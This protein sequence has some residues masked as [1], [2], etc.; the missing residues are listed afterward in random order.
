MLRPLR[1]RLAP[2]LTYAVLDAATQAAAVASLTSTLLTGDI[3]LR[4]LRDHAALKA[5]FEDA[6]AAF[7]M[8]ARQ[9]AAM[10]DT[11]TTSSTSIGPATASVGCLTVAQRVGLVAAVATAC[12]TLSWPKLMDK[13]LAKDCVRMLQDLSDA[14]L[15][16][17]P[18]RLAES[19]VP[20]VVTMLLSVFSPRAE[21]T[22]PVS[23]SLVTPSGLIA[24][25]VATPTSLAAS[26][27]VDPEQMA[28]YVWKAI[29]RQPLAAEG[30]VRQVL[31]RH[32]PPVN[33][34][35][36]KMH[37]RYLETL[38]W[39]LA[40]SPTMGFKRLS[41]SLRHH[42]MS[43]VMDN[44]QRLDAVVV[45]EELQRHGDDQ[46][47]QDPTPRQEGG[48]CRRW[49]RGDEFFEGLLLLPDEDG[50]SMPHVRSLDDG[51]DGDGGRRMDYHHSSPPQSTEWSVLVRRIAQT[52]CRANGVS[53]VAVNASD[54][55][56]PSASD[57]VGTASQEATDAAE[58]EWLT[59]LIRWH[60]EV[61]MAVPTTTALRNESSV[62]AAAAG[63]REEDGRHSSESNG[64]T[65]HG[66]GRNGGSGMW[67]TSPAGSAVDGLLP[68]IVCHIK[69]PSLS[70]NL[71]HR[72]VSAV[73]KFAAWDLPQRCAAA[74][75]LYAFVGLLYRR[76]ELDRETMLQ[77]ARRLQKMTRK[78]YEKKV[79]PILVQTL[80]R[81]SQLF[82]G[83]L[84]AHANGTEHVHHAIGG[85]GIAALDLGVLA[86]LPPEA[87][88]EM[89]QYDDDHARRGEGRVEGII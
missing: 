48:G 24:P 55:D 63:G 21:L 1:Q 71:A 37:A 36:R 67:L 58:S 60:V 19:E 30:T 12:R 88:R 22:S 26:W 28:R 25:S 81:Q 64:R 27:D 4:E 79:S 32:C 49:V 52:F 75:K 20:S 72:V 39:L 66:T 69:S 85:G 82:S 46:P 57:R 83:A 10:D 41:D 40:L 34:P 18:S 42:V 44:L 53:M 14:M 78:A 7:V 2:P 3:N 9:G 77:L 11:T 70:R 61:R 5:W 15:A 17:L 87:L 74:S 29:D 45:R 59:S 76:A 80:F 84:D 16:I 65:S 56:K 54:H 35:L 8:M 31:A 38:I 50:G 33:W 62:N 13:D 43:V 86:D 51:R 23:G 6:T 47:P 89:Q 68:L 73:E